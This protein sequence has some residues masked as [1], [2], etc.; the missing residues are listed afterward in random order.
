M[1]VYVFSSVLS[2]FKGYGRGMVVYRVN[3]GKKGWLLFSY[4]FFIHRLCGL[5][6]LSIGMHRKGGKPLSFLWKLELLTH[7]TLCGLASL[8]LNAYIRKIRKNNVISL[9]SDGF[10]AC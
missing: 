3:F 2:F 5:S 9:L 6:R 8:R 4:R 7:M 10:G 1:S